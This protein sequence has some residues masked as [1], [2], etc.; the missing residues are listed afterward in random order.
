[1][2][3]V[4]NEYYKEINSQMDLTRWKVIDYVEEL[5]Q[6]VKKCDDCMKLKWEKLTSEILNQQKSELI[7]VLDK[8]RN[9]NCPE[10]VFNLADN[11]INE[12]Q[13]NLVKTQREQKL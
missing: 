1:M 5:E 11:A 6:R 2:S 7:D 10:S 4:K 13:N 8:I 9:S 3:K 12:Y